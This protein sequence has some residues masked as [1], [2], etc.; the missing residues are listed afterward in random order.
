MIKV[1]HDY[2]EIWSYPLD[3]YTMAFVACFGNCPELH[4]KQKITCTRWGIVLGLQVDRKKQEKG[5]C[6]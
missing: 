2:L 4:L 1:L 3:I 6:C 5:R